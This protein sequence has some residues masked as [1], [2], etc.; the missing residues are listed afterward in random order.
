MSGV[1]PTIR[2]SLLAFVM[3]LVFLAQAGPAPVQAAS[4]NV[5]TILDAPDDNPGD[6]ICAT[7]AAQC[8][9]RAAVQEANALTGSDSITL[10]NGTYSL[11]AATDPDGGTDLDI[12][13]AVAINGGGPTTVID[14]GATDRAFD[15]LGTGFVSIANVFITNGSASSGGTNGGGIRSVGAALQLQ[16]SNITIDNNDAPNADIGGGA[17]FNSLGSTTIAESTL[18]GNNV[19]AG[20]GGGGAIANDQGSVTLA[21]VTLSGNSA[22]IGGAVYN[23]GPVSL[24]TVSANNVTV[25]DSTATNGAV[26]NDG[27]NVTFR[28]SIIA[29]NSAANCSVGAGSSIIST[30]HN[31]SS[32]T[33]CTFAAAGDMNDTDPQL[34]SLTDNGGPT[35]THALL[36]GTPAVDTGDDDGCA[37]TDQRGISRPQ[38]AHCDIGAFE[39]EVPLTQGDV[40]CA[41]GVNAIDA[42][43]ILRH[44]AAL[45]VDQTQP[46]PLVGA[47]VAGFPFGDVDCSGGINAIDALKILRHNAALGVIQ[48]EPCTD[49]GVALP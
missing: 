16:L 20:T 23:A 10:P 27:G 38:G 22:P 3:I 29:A 37:D 24:G 44:N 43:K 2:F 4:F 40:D 48:T 9:L 8:S 5:D 32:D 47:T 49:I 15:I 34:Q 12:T 17:L 21:N 36:P 26:H 28:N 31:L 19:G 1:T 42:L 25:T 13:Q 39:L 30:G 11:S 41:G 33:S 45:S 7:A 35:F 18:S 46:C 6:G 14:A